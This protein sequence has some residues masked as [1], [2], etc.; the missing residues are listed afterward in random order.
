MRKRYLLLGLYLTLFVLWASCV[1]AEAPFQKGATEWGIS[2]G[3]GGNFPIGMGRNVKEDIQFYFLTPS[4]G[5]VLEKWGGYGSLEFVA[6]GFLS[7]AQQDSKDRYGVGITPLFAYNFES[8]GRAVP[9]L[10]LGA[11]ILYTNLD[12]EGFGSHLNF[13]PQGGIG[14]RY[15]VAHG[16][17]LKLSY[18][19]HHI[20]NAYIDE[21][22]RSIDSHFFLIG[23]S[24]LSVPR[25]NTRPR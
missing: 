19:V 2:G 21:E 7:Y 1:Y 4:W 12:P 6:E 22:N 15:E 5:K 20:S 18:R 24:F 9:F 13:T 17:F 3:F 10:E 25:F 11:G 14:V 8:L 23:I 16:R